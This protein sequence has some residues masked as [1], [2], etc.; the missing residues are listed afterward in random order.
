M[1]DGG[2]IPG[3][4]EVIALLGDGSRFEGKLTFEGTVRIDGEFAG[5]IFSRDTLVVGPGGQV[6]ADLDVGT[7]VLQGN[8]VGNVNATD[9]VDLRA[10]GRLEGNIVAPNVT[11]ERGAFFD[12]KCSMAPPSARAAAPQQAPPPAVSTPDGVQPAQTVAPS[13]TSGE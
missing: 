7:L 9:V 1:N 2:G 10:P 3:V 8:L 13:P 11:I 4:G 5:E 12:G 6:R